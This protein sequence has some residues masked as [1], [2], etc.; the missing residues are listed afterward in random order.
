MHAIPV[1]HGLTI[2]EYAQMING[3]M[4]NKRNQLQTNCNPMFFYNRKMKYSLPVKPSLTYRTINRSIYMLACA[5]EGTNVSVG[6]G[7]EKIS[8]LLPYYQKQF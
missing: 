5:F 6:R 8:N 4:A 2:G 1:L 7:T 3:A